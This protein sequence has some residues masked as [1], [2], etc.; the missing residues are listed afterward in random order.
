[1][2]VPE[3]RFT[4]AE[5]VPAGMLVHVVPFSPGVPPLYEGLKHAPQ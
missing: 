2:T 3:G 1:M 5:E 4:D